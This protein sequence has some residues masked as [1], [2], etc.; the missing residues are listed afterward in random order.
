MKERLDR[1]LVERGFFESGEKARRAVMAGIVVVGGRVELKPGRMCTP[2]SV[3]EIKEAQR[4]VGRGGEKL[5]AALQRFGIPAAGRRCLDIGASTGGFTD[6]LLQAGAASVIALDVGRGQIAQKLRADRRVT[7]M[8]GINARYLKE[9]DLPYRPDLVTIDVSFISLA[10]IIPRVVELA[11]E[12]ADLVALVKPQFEAGRKYVG[13]GGVVKDG[14]I[15]ARVLQDICDLCE[16]LGLR[17]E[18]MME[19]PL[20]GPAGNKEFFIHAVKP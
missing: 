7:V 11:A 6:C 10:K 14:R 18:G 17:V 19:S 5:A 12:G 15:H 13:R 20:R 4:Y 8:E 16:S 3:I 2:D 1:L 9:G